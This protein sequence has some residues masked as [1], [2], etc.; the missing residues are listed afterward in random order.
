M[1]AK[2]CN[3]MLRFEIFLLDY[4]QTLVCSKL[5]REE[6]SK[7][8]AL[9]KNAE[10]PIPGVSFS[11]SVKS[12]GDILNKGQKIFVTPTDYFKTKYRQIFTNK[13]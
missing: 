9:S 5:R 3:Q 6:S 1:P 10:K 7:N 2:R 11:E 12:V 13:N 8:W 4:E